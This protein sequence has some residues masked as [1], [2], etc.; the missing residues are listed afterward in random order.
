MVDNL[1]CFVYNI[2]QTKHILRRFCMNRLKF[3]VRELC[4]IGIFTTL[5][6]VVSQLSVPMPYGVPMTLQT[7]VI[8]FAGV[9]L[10]AKNGTVSTLI[11][12]VLGAIGVPVFAGYMGGPGTLFGMTGGFILSFPLMALAAGV[13]EGKNN[14][15]WWLVSGLVAGALLNYICG[16]LWFSFVMS[17]DLKAAFAAC[18]LPFIPTS[19]IKIVLVAV[20]GRQIKRA[21]AGSKLLN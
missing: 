13:G 7:F 21:L 15:I 16:M 14:A 8:P 1:F 2:K 3:S 11:Y 10:G 6:A 9:V 4:F 19:I 18:V 17:V 12:V 20:L 5:I